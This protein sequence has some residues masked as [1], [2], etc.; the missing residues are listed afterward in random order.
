MSFFTTIR[1]RSGRMTRELKVSLPKPA[2][3]YK[4]SEALN[5]QMDGRE[6]PA[7]VEIE[8]SGWNDTLYVA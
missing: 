7:Y 3:Q 4:T 6:I 5:I 1:R 2:D 8:I